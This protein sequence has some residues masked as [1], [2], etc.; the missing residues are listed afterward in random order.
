[1]ATTTVRP[2]T[3]A[4]AQR[5]D[6]ALIHGTSLKLVGNEQAP[7]RLIIAL[8]GAERTGKCLPGRA[9][10]TDAETG[11]RIRVEDLVPGT[12]LCGLTEDGAACR[13]RVSGVRLDGIK[14]VWRLMLADGRTCCAT[15][16]HRFWIDQLGWLPL[17]S[18]QPGLVMRAPARLDTEADIRPNPHVPKLLAYLLADGALASGSVKFTKKEPRVLAEFCES[19]A[20][21]GFFTKEMANK[22]GVI[23][24]G[25]TGRK[26]AGAW[27]HHVNPMSVFRTQYGLYGAAANKQIPAEVFT[28]GRP[29]LALFLNRYFSCDGWISAARKARNRDRIAS[30]QVGVCSASETLVRQLAHLLLRFGIVG[31]I[32]PRVV[33]GR[34]YWNWET[35]TGGA[36]A[37][38]S[39]IGFFGAD[40]EKAQ[41]L[42]AACTVR[43]GYMDP[44]RTPQHADSVWIPVKSVEQEPL[45]LP[46]YDIEVDHPTHAFVVDDVWAHNTTFALSAPGPIAYFQLDPGG[47]DIVP[48]V[49]KAFPK[50][51]LYLAKYYCDIKPGM[52]EREVEAVATPVWERFTKDYES[53]LTRFRSIVVDTSTEAWEL[54]RLAEFGKVGQVKAI[55]Y[56]P[57]N[58]EYRRLL[59][60]PYNHDCNVIFIHKQ[61]RTYVGDSWNGKYERAGFSATGYEVQAELRTFRD[62]DGFQ[63]E[64]ENCR[65]NADLEGEVVP[66]VMCDFAG[67]GQLVY[68]DSTAADWE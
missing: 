11:R 2:A 35:T 4:P 43:P 30:L 22:D 1:M 18:V 25:C 10:V 56:G 49:R 23:T 68:P 65:Q 37:F 21:L 9:L 5:P 33:G 58:A 20:E 29:S 7:M 15:S 34:T 38:V 66:E 40:H 26:G 53:A 63:V 62:E 50:K 60:L 31:R 27:Q 54:L 16:E 41:A 6:P 12:D 42:V 64:I 39:R 14:T 19:A 28:W 32:R 61:K 59:R 52:N 47:E 45:D 36:L 24:V 57:V 17:H 44:P 55:H 13:V 48:K 8:R 67:V 3:T 46:V 51:Q